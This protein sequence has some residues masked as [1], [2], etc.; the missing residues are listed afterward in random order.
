MI[1]CAGDEGMK[2]MDNMISKKW[3]SS[4]MIV[5]LAKLGL[6]HPNPEY[7]PFIKKLLTIEE[8]IGMIGGKPGL[9]YYIVGYTQDKLIYLD[10]HYV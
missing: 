4:M 5:V 3:K 9:A 10:P 8:S 1:D 7:L 6:D 2:D